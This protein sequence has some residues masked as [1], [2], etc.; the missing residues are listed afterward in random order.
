MSDVN[1]VQ[2]ILLYI[3]NK[4]SINIYWRC[5]PFSEV[6]SCLL[7]HKLFFLYQSTWFWAFNFIQLICF[8]LRTILINR[9]LQCYLKMGKLVP[10]RLI[11]LILQN[12][13]YILMVIV[14]NLCNALD[15]I[16][17]VTMLITPIQEQGIIFHFL[18]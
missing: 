16:I 12:V 17:I 15:K 10:S 14:L 7:G 3:N 1:V 6:W 9:A 5:F 11:F 18:V 13:T 8:F 2:F 4:L